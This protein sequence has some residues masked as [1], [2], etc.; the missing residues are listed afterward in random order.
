M[1]AHPRAVSTAFL[2]MMIERG[3]VT[4]VH[5]PLVLLTDHGQVEL[6]DLDGGTTTV[7]STV[8]YATPEGRATVLRYPMARGVA[9][10][11]ER[12]E[13]LLRNVSAQ[14]SGGEPS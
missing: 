3:D 14:P 7:S 4:V 8:R 12:L 10:G 5:E 2:R 6:P 11:T 9:E 1:W 13:A